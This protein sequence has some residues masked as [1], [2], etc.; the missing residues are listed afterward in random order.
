MTALHLTRA[1]SDPTVGTMIRETR[2]VRRVLAPWLAT[3][4]TSLSVL[5]PLLDAVERPDGT[6]IEAEHHARDCF[7]G[8]DH[9]ICLQLG[10]D[11]GLAEGGRAGPMPGGDV[12]GLAHPHRF[13]LPAR[14]AVAPTRSRA[15]PLA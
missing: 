3:L 12:Y 11:R 7:R 4:M 6:V 14:G 9:T 5:V 15:P 13:H 1:L 10:A 8:H 2:L